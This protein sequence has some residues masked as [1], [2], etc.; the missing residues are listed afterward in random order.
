MFESL[1]RS[2]LRSFFVVRE[3]ILSIVLVLIYFGVCEVLF[4]L[5]LDS[6]ISRS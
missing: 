3:L 2:L 1:S 4:S 6:F 5:I